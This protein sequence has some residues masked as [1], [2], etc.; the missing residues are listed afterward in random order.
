[1][2]NENWKN[3]SKALEIIFEDGNRFRNLPSKFKKD[4]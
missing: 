2:R 3:I 4:K 1:M